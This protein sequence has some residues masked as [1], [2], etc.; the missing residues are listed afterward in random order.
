MKTRRF[1]KIISVHVE[2]SVKLVCNI[3]TMCV[4]NDRNNTPERRKKM[5]K[6]IWVP[7][8]FHTKETT[9]NIGSP[10]TPAHT[11]F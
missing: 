11:H 1:C 7:E 8:I 3:R 2:W 9:D 5:Q 6:K 4:P 10:F